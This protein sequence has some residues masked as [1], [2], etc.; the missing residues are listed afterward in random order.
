M[1][2]LSLRELE[3]G[4]SAGFLGATDGRDWPQPSQP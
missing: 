1:E 3:L 4:E 2:N